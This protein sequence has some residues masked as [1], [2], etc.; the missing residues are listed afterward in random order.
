[1][2]RNPEILAQIFL[3]L[4]FPDK[5]SGGPCT[6]LRLQSVPHHLCLLQARTRGDQMPRVQVSK[7]CTKVTKSQQVC[8][9][10]ELWKAG[11]REEPL[12]WEGRR[13]A[14]EPNQEAREAPEQGLN[15]A[16]SWNNLTFISVVIE[17]RFPTFFPLCS[18]LYHRVIWDDWM[19]KSASYETRF[20]YLVHLCCPDEVQMC[21]GSSCSAIVV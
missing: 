13:G 12:A 3:Q 21:R 15:Q 8:F 2:K 18:W 7:S 17:N 11:S 9:Q 19:S 1:M 5:I 10:G 20:A 6:N 16:F 4:T 14:S